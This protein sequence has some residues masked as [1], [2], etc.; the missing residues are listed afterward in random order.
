ML[1]LDGAPLPVQAQSLVAQVLQAPASVL[2]QGEQAVQ[3]R[4]VVR[5]VHVRHLP[6]V[7]LLKLPPHHLQHHSSSTAL[8]ALCHAQDMY[9]QG[10][11]RI[12][13]GWSAG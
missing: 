3:L 8:A 6:R 1:A 2:Q 7:D 10:Y 5:H 9:R 4:S 12:K 13:L 11:Q